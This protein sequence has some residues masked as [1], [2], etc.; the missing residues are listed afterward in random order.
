MHK[1][2][3][4][5]AAGLMVMAVAPEKLAT[6]TISQ[7]AKPLIVETGLADPDGRGVIGMGRTV[8]HIVAIAKVMMRG[9]QELAGFDKH[10]ADMLVAVVL[11]SNQW[12][13]VEVEDV[14]GAVPFKD[15]KLV[16]QVAAAG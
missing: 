6:E 2:A 16:G 14:H 15:Q 4:P 12:Q 9:G 11:R 1:L 3:K 13:L 8:R 7:I 10:F 5:H